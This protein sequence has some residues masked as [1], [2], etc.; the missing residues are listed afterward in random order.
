MKLISILLFCALVGVY[1]GNP[2]TCSG[3]AINSRSVDGTCNNLMSPEQGAANM[4][5]TRLLP[6]YFPEEK[7]SP[8]A[9]LISN[10]VAWISPAEGQTLNEQGVNIFETAFGQFLNHDKTHQGTR[11]GATDPLYLIPFPEDDPFYNSPDPARNFVGVRD[12]VLVTSALPGSS[13]VEP[14]VPST[15]TSY[16]DLSSL[17][18]NSETVMNAMRKM[19]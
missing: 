15:S 6:S 11:T 16:L 4:L 2:M 14:Q 9:R 18:G 3:D 19:R 17:Y 1:A 13:K 8:N 5:L 7:L 10:K 12:S